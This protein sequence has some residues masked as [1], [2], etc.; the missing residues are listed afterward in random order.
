MNLW[1]SNSDDSVKWIWFNLRLGIT[2]YNFT[3]IRRFATTNWKNHYG[4]CFLDCRFISIGSSNRKCILWMYHQNIWSQITVTIHLNTNDGKSL[5]ERKY[6]ETK[7]HFFFKCKI[8]DQLVA[9]SVL[10]KCLLLIRSSVAS[11]FR[12]WRCC[13]SCTSVFNRNIKRSVTIKWFTFSN[14][15]FN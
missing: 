7:K 3:Y 10:P 9:H 15:C 12:C 8:P 5:M 1:L 11:R 6:E 13:S 14:N 2:K 4:S